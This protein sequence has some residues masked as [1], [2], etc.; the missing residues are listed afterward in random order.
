M[1]LSDPVQPVPSIICIGGAVLDRKYK[2]KA[3]LAPGTSNPVSGFRSFGGVARNVT[4]NLARLG[5]SVGFVTIV[6]E[7]ETGR[8]LT[9][10]LAD[11]GVDIS[12]VVRSRDRPSA[13]YVAV[14]NPDNELALGLADM[15]IF[16]LLSPEHIAACRPYLGRASWVFAD[17]NLP[18]ASLAALI[19]LRAGD[20]FKLAIDAVSTPKV[21]R[22]PKDLSGID[23][24]F[25]NQDEAAVLLG[26][27]VGENQ[28]VEAQ[29]GDLLA[30][31]AASTVITRGADGFVVAQA[32]GV[33]AFRPAP[34]KPVDVTGAGD[35]MVA[36]TLYSLLAGAPLERAARIGA[37]A[38]TLTTESAESV[39]PDLSPEVLAAAMH[40]IPA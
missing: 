3:E 25:L 40:R 1:K 15:E 13:E 29:A 16:D 7:D 28:P 2:A 33:R 32:G 17:C 35:A 6:G 38:A 31:G 26:V 14:L 27:P 36:G 12:Q 8:A 39:R 21:R 20:R 10:H 37:L 19:A 30:R 24:L 5:V 18:A 11:L 22:L 23:L 34:A 9:A 4:E